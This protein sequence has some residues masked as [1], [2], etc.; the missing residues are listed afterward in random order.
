MK[1]SRKPYP[2]EFKQEAVRLLTEQRLSRSQVAR[3]LGV[4]PETL[5]RWA[6]EL[7][8]DNS[9]S[10]DSALTPPVSAAELAR[11][12][13]ENEQLCMERD[14]LK[15]AIGIFSPLPQC[16]RNSSSSPPRRASIH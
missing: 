4:D 10:Q 15:K 12:R 11:L 3:D 8:S 7:A 14:S 13:R 1:R 6:R 2:D 16:A 5:R 9:V